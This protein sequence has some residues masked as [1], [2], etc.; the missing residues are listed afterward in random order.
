MIPLVNPLCKSSSRWFRCVIHPACSQPLSHIDEIKKR[1]KWIIGAVISY[2]VPGFLIPLNKQANLLVMVW[3]VRICFVS[4]TV[5]YRIV[6]IC[7]LLWLHGRLISLQV[8]VCA[9]EYVCYLIVCTVYTS[10]QF[11]YKVYWNLRYQSINQSHFR[12][13][14]Q[15]NITPYLALLFGNKEGGDFFRSHLHGVDIPKAHIPKWKYRNIV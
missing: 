2:I 12:H 11:I 1:D 6:G 4:S 8:I 5:N 7:E 15:F 10:L 14:L 13:H 3:E 9:S